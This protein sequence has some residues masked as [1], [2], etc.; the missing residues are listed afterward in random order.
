MAERAS[1]VS[2]AIAKYDMI[3]ALIETGEIIKAKILAEE[4]GLDI[5]KIKKG[6]MG[7]TNQQQPL[8]LQKPQQLMPLVR[9]VAEPTATEA[10]MAAEPQEAQQ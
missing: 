8:K 4:M 2:P 3:I 7:G 10:Q 9:G 6:E 5:D 1:L